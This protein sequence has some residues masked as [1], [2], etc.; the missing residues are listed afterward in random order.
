MHL[1]ECIFVPREIARSKGCG[2]LM[3]FKNIPDIISDPNFCNKAFGKGS[4]HLL[5]TY[6]NWSIEFCCLLSLF[7]GQNLVVGRKG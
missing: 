4:R 2:G 7:I 1:D 3:L 6:R 5:S